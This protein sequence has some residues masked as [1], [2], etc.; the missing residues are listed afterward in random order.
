VGEIKSLRG[1]RATSAAF[2]IPQT[3]DVSIL[4]WLVREADLDWH[5]FSSDH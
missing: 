1:L 2:C 4:I 5:T 3:I